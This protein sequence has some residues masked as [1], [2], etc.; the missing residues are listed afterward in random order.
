MNDYDEPYSGDDA[1]SE[2]S[3][4]S[5]ASSGSESLFPSHNDKRK[6]RIEE[7]LDDDADASD[8]EK[9]ESHHANDVGD[10]G[11]PQ[12]DHAIRST[13]SDESD[14]EDIQDQVLNAE[15]VEKAKAMIVSRD[16][17][18][19]ESQNDQR[20]SERMYDPLIQLVQMLRLRE[21]SRTA[22]D[23]FLGRNSAQPKNSF[24]S[25]IKA[26]RR[27]VAHDNQGDTVRE[28][29]I[30]AFNK[31]TELTDYMAGP[32]GIPGILDLSRESLIDRLNRI[33]FEYR[34]PSG[35]DMQE[36]RGPINYDGLTRLAASH[37]IEFR[38]ARSSEVW[39]PMHSATS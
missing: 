28:K 18:W 7:A 36:T 10:R 16:R 2:A 9:E 20:Q 8:S 13:T 14:G 25:S 26:A 11:T 4:E 32:G 12:Q 19:S 30:V 6:R 37:A 15:S 34:I 38:K 31:I 39:A 22:M 3:Q 27:K 35:S 23:R 33:P 24:K 17:Y 29:D 5:E 21:T 1:A